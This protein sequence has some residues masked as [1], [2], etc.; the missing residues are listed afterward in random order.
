MP[1]IAAATAGSGVCCRP[2]TEAIFVASS[3]DGEDAS[4]MGMPELPTPS[5]DADRVPLVMKS[6]M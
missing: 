1:S 4:A 2:A 5:D 6:V 3:S